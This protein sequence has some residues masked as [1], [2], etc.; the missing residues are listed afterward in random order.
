MPAKREGFQ[1]PGIPERVLAGQRLYWPVLAVS[2][3]Q[4]LVF[5]SGQV[6]RAL[7][8]S[9]VAPGDMAGQIRHLGENIRLCLEAAGAT[10][11][12]LVKITCYTTDIEEF[13]RHADVRNR[14]FG[15]AMPTS[16]AV[17]VRRLGHPDWLVEIE[18]IAVV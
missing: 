10:L 13:H 9:P 14:Y 12:D 3:A 15:K 8:G 6:P 16:T 18:A 1:P 17:E 4:R 2:G 5:V 7:D 11:D